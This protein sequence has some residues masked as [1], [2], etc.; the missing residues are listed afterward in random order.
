MTRV[1]S[2]QITNLKN[3]KREKIQSIQENEL[4]SPAVR[5]YTRSK[6]ESI[7][8]PPSESADQICR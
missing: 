7:K 1:H 4:A 3:V 8:R 2:T 5:A 6:R